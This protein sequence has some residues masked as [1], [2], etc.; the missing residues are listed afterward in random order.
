MTAT[1]RTVWLL[2]A[3]AMALSAPLLT[4]QG[5][6]LESDDVLYARL[7][8]DLAG[9]HPTFGINSHTYR[10]GFI[11]PMAALYRTFGIHDWTT[12]AFSL[13]SSFLAI[14]VAAYAAD[15]LYG[16]MAAA[17]AAL[18]CGFNPI[19]YWL[20]SVGMPDL[21]AGFLYGLFVVGWLLIVAN[22][23]THKQVWAAV[24]GMA[25]AWAVA[26]RETTAPMILLTLAG[27]LILGW[28]Q[29]RWRDIP[30]KAW[31]LGCGLIGIPYLLYLWWHTGNPFYFLE[32]AQ[33]GYAY[34]GAPWLRPLEGRDLMARLTGL[35]ILHASLEGYLFALLP[36]IVAAAIRGLPGSG[37]DVIRQH[38]V[39]SILS[40]LVILSHFSASFSQWV[41]IHLDL[42]FGSALI[43]P[44]A[45]LAAGACLRL[46]ERSPSMT[47]Q[48]VV[49]LISLAGAG[50]IGLGWTHHNSWSLL[51]GAATVLAGLAVLT[52]HRTPKPFLSMI[53]VLLLIGN[54]GWHLVRLFP[55][56]AARNLAVRTDA[57]AVP[58]DSVSFILTDPG[59]A[60]ILPYLH[61]FEP[62]PQVATWKGTG[63][64][65]RPFNWTTRLEE[66]W[67][68]PYL[69]VWHRRKAAVQTQ[70]WDGDVPQWT[71][72]ELVKGRRI[73]PFVNEPPADFPSFD[74][75]RTLSDAYR[76]WPPSGIYL[77]E[78]RHGG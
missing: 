8:S 65:E 59:T 19:L 29:S 42:R 34:A 16:G 4:Y 74:R 5:V 38:L 73:H 18:L 71:L 56:H 78:D 37:D 7:A 2:S 45:V 12:V 6:V 46:R 70:R 76:G 62:V 50:L 44:A 30:V 68:R 60:L 31:L 17:V 47:E 69:L 14:V 21:P 51:G 22:R 58:W 13:V 32:A 36:L 63:E 25:A 26:T 35:K 54:W 15:R 1:V 41:P 23:V 28:R 49:G 3:F 20:A 11:L 40:P 75:P 66:P 64:R 43:I 39:I 57:Q 77:I 24:A 33:G 67:P 53:I 61:Q 55:E 72:G 48:G 52:A 9:G 10:L 27:F